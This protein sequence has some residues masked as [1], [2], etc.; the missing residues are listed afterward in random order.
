MEDLITAKRD[1]KI[2]L[3][4]LT[5]GDPALIADSNMENLADKGNGNYYY[6]DSAAEAIRVLQDRLSGTIYTI[7]KDVK[8][9]VEFNPTKVLKYRLIG[10]DNRV[11]E[12]SE[13]NNDTVDSGELGAGHTVTAFYQIEYVGGMSPYLFALEPT[14]SSRCGCVTNRPNR[15]KVR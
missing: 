12:N 3:T 6:I 9:Q 8:V 14:I 13:F 11:M 1:E 5:F 2:F 10:Y 15:T 7:A 4:V